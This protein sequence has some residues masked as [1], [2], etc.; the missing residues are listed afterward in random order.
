MTKIFFVAIAALLGYAPL[1]ALLPPLYQQ[2]AELKQ[3]IENEEL[4]NYLQSGELILTIE[5]QDHGYL[6]VTN[7]QKVFA[8]VIIQPQHT[9]GPAQF[10]I[11]FH[12]I[13]GIQ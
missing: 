13:D 11:S 1:F 12:K 6:I 3:I 2:L 9:P 10:S 4:P 5:R 8:E 7:Q